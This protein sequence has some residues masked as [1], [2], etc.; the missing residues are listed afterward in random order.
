M[1]TTLSVA[2]ADVEL[3]R[4]E[5]DDAIEHLRQVRSPELTPKFFRHW[6]WRMM[7]QLGLSN[8]WLL[9]GNF[10]NARLEADL[11]LQSA[12][13]TADPHMQALAWEMKTRVA[14]AEQH[15]MAPREYLHQAV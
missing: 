11:L 4:H 10:L 2:A 1:R 9:S 3:G 14:M 5:Y 13:S 12:L 8:V 6:I 15:W 7:A